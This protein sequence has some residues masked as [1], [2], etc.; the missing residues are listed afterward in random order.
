MEGPIKPTMETE[1]SL[2]LTVNCRPT[3]NGKKIRQNLALGFNL[4]S[5]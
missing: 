3:E 2:S 4:K 5:M 1:L